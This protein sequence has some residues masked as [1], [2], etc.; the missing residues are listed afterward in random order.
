MRN[1]GMAVSEHHPPPAPEPEAS[2]PKGPAFSSE[3]GQAHGK[4]GTA[5]LRIFRF[6]A[7]AHD[8]REA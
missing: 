6:E 8:L 1:K 5:S 3:Y 2:A 7:T 4:A